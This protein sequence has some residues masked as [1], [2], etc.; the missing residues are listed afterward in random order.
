VESIFDSVLLVVV[1]VVVELVGCD[2]NDGVTLVIGLWRSDNKVVVPFPIP[3]SSLLARVC[4]SFLPVD[5]SADR[6]AA[7]AP[8]DGRA[9]KE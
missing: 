5:I 8:D 7:E 3:F 9:L 2:S 1:A 4:P 6:E